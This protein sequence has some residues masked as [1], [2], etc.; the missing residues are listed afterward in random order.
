MEDRIKILLLDDDE[1]DFLI[2]RKLIEVIPGN[3]YIISWTDDYHVAVNA[4]K[5]QLYDVYLVDYNIGKYNGLDFVK[6]VSG[7]CCSPLILLTGQ[8]DPEIDEK[9]MKA[10]ASDYL[11]KGAIN[12]DYL[13]RAIRYSIEQ[14]K[15]LKEIRKLNSELE[16]R[17][18]CR[19][20]E[21]EEVIA[22]LQNTNKDLEELLAE[23]EKTENQ[24]KAAFEKERELNEMKSRFVSMASHEFRTPLSTIS[25]SAA[26]IERY[27]KAVNAEKKARHFERIKKSVNH[28][29]DIL[30][31]LL[32]ISR[33]EEGKLIVQNSE[34]DIT[35]L[36][37]DLVREMQSSAKS[38]Q[39]ITYNHTGGIKVFSDRKSLIHIICNLL[40]NSIKYSDEGKEIILDTK[41]SM[42]QLE[43]RVKDSGIGIPE[44]EQKNIF[45]RFFRAA[46]VSNI[47]GTG[48]GLNIVKKYLELLNGTISFESK[49]AKGTEFLVKIPLEN[50]G[51]EKKLI[52]IT[53]DD[54]PHSS[55][56]YPV[57]P[58]F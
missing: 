35:A 25:S 11:V 36:S 12:S 49:E 58:L 1:E 34:L 28:L 4:V 16:K 40:S 54:I 7:S 31:D 22:Q 18:K 13:D 15:N 57:L 46:N 24:L 17:V 42:H 20:Q 3:K 56:K 8:G 39:K 45:E 14:C 33:L 41:I 47:Q 32:S 48:L 27:D 55:R 50:P 10:G 23:R 26:L 5:D 30:N 52:K 51:D 29:T 6:S 19:T 44:E 2:T 43:I 9:A 53:K 21:L 38:G 37:S